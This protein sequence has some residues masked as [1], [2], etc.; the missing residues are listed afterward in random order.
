M[1][2]VQVPDFEK[3]VAVVLKLL[4]E[5]NNFSV[6]ESEGGVSLYQKTGKKIA[7]LL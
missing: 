3:F 1:G 5:A 6:K 7:R 2:K 4:S